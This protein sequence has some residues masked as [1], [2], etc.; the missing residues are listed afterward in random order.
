M[1]LVKQS[2]YSEDLKTLQEFVDRFDE[3][4]FDKIGLR[5]F[6]D[7]SSQ[8]YLGH[9]AVKIYTLNKPKN[10]VETKY[11]RKISSCSL[12][13]SSDINPNGITDSTDIGRTFTIQ[14]EVYC[15]KRVKYGRNWY[16]DTLTKFYGYGR[17]IDEILKRFEAFTQTENFTNL[18]L[19]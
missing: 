11:Q 19:K 18:Y 9:G 14:L 3:I 15:E 17:T 1:E 16:D 7:C 8:D 6:I 12:R 13:L 4:Y 2:D 5:V 10:F